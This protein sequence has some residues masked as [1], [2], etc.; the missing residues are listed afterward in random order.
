M[1]IPQSPFTFFDVGFKEIDRLAELLVFAAPFVHF[2]FDETFNS[3]RHDPTEIATLELL[4]EIGAPGQEPGFHHGRFDRQIG[5][6]QFE[7]ISHGA[8]AMAHLK[9][10]VPEMM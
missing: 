9:T 8:H 1:K 4:K 5:G 3:S 7:T 10:K 6:S 2:F